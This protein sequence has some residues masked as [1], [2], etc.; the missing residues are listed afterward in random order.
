MFPFAQLSG[1]KSPHSSSSFP[2]QNFGGNQFGNEDGKTG[3]TRPY[4]AKGLPDLRYS[5]YF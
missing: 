1:G 2:S 5:L 4:L 3:V